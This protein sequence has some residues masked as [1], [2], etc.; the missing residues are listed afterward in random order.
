MSFL[1]PSQQC[2]SM[3]KVNSNHQPSTSGLASFFLCSS[4]CIAPIT[5]LWC[6]HHFIFT[7]VL[8]PSL[9]T[10]SYKLDILLEQIFTACVPL[11]M[12]INTFRRGR[13]R[14]EFSAI[15]PNCHLCTPFYNTTWTLKNTL[16][17]LI[18]ENFA[19]P[20]MLLLYVHFCAV[21]LHNEL[22]LLRT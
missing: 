12:A 2:Q 15:L 9:S 18:P 5:P 13:R 10:P 11:L 8:W 22:H 7:I 17:A 19:S 4:P 6:Q 20:V 3:L 16:P 14:Y 1:L 21:T